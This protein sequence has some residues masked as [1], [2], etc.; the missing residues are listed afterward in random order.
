MVPRVRGIM[1]ELGRS[2]RLMPEE[3]DHEPINVEIISV[4]PVFQELDY[5]DL[6]WDIQRP[7]FFKHVPI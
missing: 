7:P 3:A 6:Y 1:G 2:G 4:G 5:R